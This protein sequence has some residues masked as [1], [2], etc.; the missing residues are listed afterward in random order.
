M[1]RK[2]RLL[3]IAVAIAVGTSAQIA[4][5]HPMTNFDACAGNR[6]RSVVC[7]DHYL[8]LAR[9]GVY[10]HAH[11]EPTHRGQSVRI[12]RRNP[13]GRWVKVANKARLGKQGWVRWLWDTKPRH[14]SDKR[15]LLSRHHPR[16][17][18]DL[19]PLSCGDAVGA[20]GLEPRPS[21]CKGEADVLVKGLS[22][23]LGVSLSTSQYLRV[24]PSCYADVM[25]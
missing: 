15:Y 2:A 20:E 10:I 23:D 14:A 22:R 21:P 7:R 13:N 8:I 4:E 12:W 17:W 19:T 6:Y 1:S 18:T 25:H 5:G 11:A 9:D 16:P 24:S 3:V